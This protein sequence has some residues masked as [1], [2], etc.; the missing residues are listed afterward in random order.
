MIVEV[1]ELPA[2]T[3]AAVAVKVNDLPELV[4]ESD[5]AVKRLEKSREPSPLASS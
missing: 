1:V 5:H 3:A 4:D 2:E